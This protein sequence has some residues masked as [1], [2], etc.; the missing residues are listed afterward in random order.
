MKQIKNDPLKAKTTF[1]T[2][3]LCLFLAFISCLTAFS[4]WLFIGVK[5]AFNS[6]YTSSYLENPNFIS[7]HHDE[8]L[9]I[10]LI[11]YVQNFLE[12]NFGLIFFILL[13][14][15]I[16]L[17]VI[18]WFA[19]KRNSYV[20]MKF[21]SSVTVLSGLLMLLFPIALL[22]LDVHNMVK[23]VNHQNTILFSAFL[24]SS[25]FIMIA[26]GI[27]LLAI[28]F[29]EEFLAATILKNRRTSYIRSKEKTYDENIDM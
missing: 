25:C 5:I 15:C 16:L 20:F 9:I 7:M 2:Y 6:G 18:M 21:Q 19:T 14:L 3:F 13:I 27:L 11:Y 8:H 1:G 22:M 10:R 26:I 12:N 28:A 4:F 24:K 17:I 23:L 29:V